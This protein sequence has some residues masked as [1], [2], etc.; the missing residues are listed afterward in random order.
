MKLQQT[1][2]DYNRPT[3]CPYCSC[4]WTPDCWLEVLVCIRNVIRPINSTKAFRDFPRFYTKCWF[5][6]QNGGF[7]ACFSCS[8]LQ[9]NFI[10]FSN[11]TL[12]K[13]SKYLHNAIPQ[14][15]SAIKMLDLC[16]LLHNRSS[17]LPSTFPFTSL[18]FTSLPD[19][20]YQ[21]DERALPRNLQGSKRFWHSPITR[22]VVPVIASPSPPPVFSLLF[23]FLIFYLLCNVDRIRANPYQSVHWYGS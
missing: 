20:L 14:T 21:K 10:F 9:N 22:S 18:C 8:R 15:Q 1:T 6:T 16:P 19:Y 13:R 17:S 2:T 5:G 11:A 4:V 23:S 7:A 12:S 3:N